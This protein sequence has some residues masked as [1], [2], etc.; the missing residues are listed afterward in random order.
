MVSNDSLESESIICL[1]GECIR[2]D[3]KGIFA[4]VRDVV[5]FNISCKDSNQTHSTVFQKKFLAFF[6]NKL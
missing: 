4:G 2:Y 6:S 5:F 1:K 3:F